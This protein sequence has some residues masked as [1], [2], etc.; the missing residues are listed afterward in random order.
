LIS[1]TASP[2]SKRPTISRN[3]SAKRGYPS[4]VDLDENGKP[5]VR[6]VKL[7]HIRHALGDVCVF[8]KHLKKS[9]ISVAPP[10][11][12]LENVLVTPDLP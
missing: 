9:S 12:S 11:D 10:R 7:P 6:P 4:R 8:D 2:R 1:L 3:C 5:L